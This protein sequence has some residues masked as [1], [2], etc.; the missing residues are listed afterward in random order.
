MFASVPN[1]TEFYS[2]DINKGVECIRLLNE[3]ISESSLI[4]AVISKRS[5]EITNCT[6]GGNCASGINPAP[7]PLPS[8]NQLSSDDLLQ[9]SSKSRSSRSYGQGKSDGKQVEG[10]MLIS[11]EDPKSS[12]SSITEVPDSEYET[13]S[14]SESSDLTTETDS[15]LYPGSRQCDHPEYVVFTWV[16]CL[17]ALATCLRLHYLVKTL[18]GIVMVAVYALLIVVAYPGVF[19]N[20]ALTGSLCIAHRSGI[21]RTDFD[22]LLDEPR[23]QTIEKVKTVGATY[24]AASGLNP[25]HKDVMLQAAEEDELEH[26][27]ALV[28][29]AIAMKQRLDDVNKH[30]FNSFRLRVGI[31]FGPLVGGVIGAR[32]PVFDIWGNTVNEASRMDSTGTMNHIQVPK[33]TAMVLEARGYQ[34]QYRGVVAVKGKGD[35]ET[36]YVVGRKATRAAGFSRMPSQY[37]SLAAVVYGMVQARRRQTIK[38]GSGSGAGSSSSGLGGGSTSGG[39]TGIGGSGNSSSKTRP[40]KVSPENDN[41]GGSGS[42]PSSSNQLSHSGHHNRLRNFSSMR[43]SSGSSTSAGGR[44]G[45]RS[46]GW[47]SRRRS[48]T[49]GPQTSQDYL[50]PGDASGGHARS[51]PNMRQLSVD[52]SVLLSPS[53]GSSPGGGSPT[54][55]ASAPQ[56]PIGGKNGEDGE[57]SPSF[58]TEQAQSKR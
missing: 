13:T 52:P 23:F 28:D 29:F 21:S 19:E 53:G 14:T 54:Q 15:V 58:R 34:V 12:V 10:S 55:Y 35:M 5:I 49:P 17:V 4:Y 26:L 31:S 50:S 37:N 9:H 47:T 32:K 18:L 2:E 56:T 46:R 3:I 30:S 48:P 11:S 6:R 33:E 36:Y 57:R 39:S 22:E 44:S 38:K 25:G 24:M 27:T 1:F 42:P 8:L 41:M 45:S 16:L 7:L 43:I 20:A 51:Q 40:R